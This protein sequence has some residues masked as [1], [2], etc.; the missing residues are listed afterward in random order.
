MLSIL[1]VETKPMEHNDV[2]GKLDS[3]Q[4][5]RCVADNGASLHRTERKAN[6]TVHA[7]HTAVHVQGLQ[8]LHCASPRAER[9]FLRERHRAAMKH[10]T[11]DFLEG[12]DGING[13][14]RRVR[15]FVVVEVG[16][17]DRVECNEGS[18]RNRSSG[19]CASEGG[20]NGGGHETPSSRASV[21]PQVTKIAVM[22]APTELACMPVAIG[23]Q[24]P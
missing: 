3:W 13:C 21:G 22:T 23:Q 5:L 7:V 6:C 4:V 9:G 8:G 18:R 1:A 17:V 11:R 20:G 16:D 15:F 19:G 14:G 12:T 10:E 2:P 24:Q